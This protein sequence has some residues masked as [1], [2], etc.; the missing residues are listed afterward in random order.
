L[1]PPAERVTTDGA[2]GLEEEDAGVLL[3][4]ATGVKPGVELAGGWPSVRNLLR[5]LEA[6]LGATV[7]V[8]VVLRGSAN[9]V[10]VTVRGLGSSPGLPLLDGDKEDVVEDVVD[11]VVLV[12][13]S[14]P[15]MPPSPPA[16]V[17][18]LRAVDSLVQSSAVPGARILGMAKHS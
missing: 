18:R 12:E 17:I 8:V 7:V 9:T 13:L 10:T 15:V 14:E 11:D 16:A 4:S 5:M 6:S 3:G 1:S 2:P